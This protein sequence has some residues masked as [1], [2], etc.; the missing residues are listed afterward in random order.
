MNVVDIVVP[1]YNAPDDVADCVASVLLHTD[2]RHPLIL[3][4]DASP[5]PRIAELFAR[6][7]AAGHARL[8]LL[9]NERNLGFTGTASRGLMLSRHDVVLLNSDT[10]VTAGWLDALQRCAASDARIGTIT[11]FSNNAEILSWPRFCVNNPPPD[12]AEAEATRAA[13]AAAAVPTYPDIPT[14][15]GFC[16]YVRRALLDEIGAFDPAF[17]AGYGEENDFC[18]R[19]AA[20]D[21]RNV[22]C[23]DAFVVHTGG[24]SFGDDKD[25]LVPR[26]TA[27]LLARHPGYVGMVQRYIAQDPLKPLR[28]AAATQHRRAAGPRPGVLHVIHH[29]GGGT[30]AHVRAL[31]AASIDTCRHYIVTAVDDDWAVEEH[32]ERGHVTRYALR[33]ARDETWPAFVRGIVATFGIDVVHVHNLSACRDGIVDG[34]A[35]AGV[36]YGYT[37]HDVAF[38]CPTITFMDNTG[39]YCGAMTDAAACSRCLAAQPAFASV[40][41]VAWR[42]LHQRFVDGAAFLVAPSAWAADTFARYFGRRPD[43][44]PHGDAMVAAPGVAAMLD[45]PTAGVSVAGATPAAATSRAPTMAALMPGEAAATVAVLGAVGPDKGAR[46]LERLVELAR[47]RG[48]PLRF[49]LIGYLDRERGPWQSADA[50]FTI[51]GRYAPGELPALLRHYGVRAVLYPSV[52]PETFCYTLSETWAAGLPVI[53]PPIGALAERVAANGGGVVLDTTQWGDDEA[54]FARVV[55]L[56]ADEAATGGASELGRARHD[57]A[58]IVLPSI[59][60]T[61]AATVAVYRGA[62]R[63]HAATRDDAL[64]P[65][66]LRDALGYRRW[67]PPE[68]PASVI[69]ARHSVRARL[70]RLARRLRRTG[71]GAGMHDALPAHWTEALRAR[72]R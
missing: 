54:M 29:H 15:V 57:A 43:V 70:A 32:A 65:V 10:R 50:R 1:V 42:A 11:P 6:Y 37:V 62:M 47:E 21:W 27:T 55:E 59:A 66:R 67:V 63:E 44:I 4:D 20:H 26:N 9:R 31:V 60:G 52:G 28:E 51:H 41:I 45:E 53:V 25:A 40:D 7:A 24:R 58:R 18:L 48:L 35:G 19:A 8:K 38:G 69:A 64:A 17:G 22:L 36:R 49:V 12:D 72:L 5:D 30:E 23:D 13:L 33:R 61:V 14:G 68:P 46:R 56:L 71:F 3:I 2:P 34:L 39:R 16:F